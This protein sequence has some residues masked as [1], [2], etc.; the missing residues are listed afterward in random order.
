MARFDWEQRK[1]NWE[2]AVQQ[3]IN[4]K[5]KAEIVEANYFDQPLLGAAHRFSE[6]IEWK[7]VRELIGKPC[8]IAVDIGA[9]N[10]IVSY[11]LAKDGWKTIAI[12]PDPSPLVGADAIRNL[13]MQAGIEI[14][15]HQAMGEN[16]KLGSNTASIVIARQVLHHANNLNEFAKEIARILKPGGIMVSLRDHV[17]SGPHQLNSFLER[18]PLHRYY[19]GENAFEISVYRHAFISAGLTIVKELKSFDSVVNYAPKNQND[20]RREIAG[21]LGPI[22]FL[23]DHAL[24]PTMIMTAALKLLTLL[25]RRPG[26]LVSFVCQKQ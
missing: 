2:D 8:G 21:R 22:G 20:M 19:G 6:G 7:A 23:A 9:G 17:I 14:E 13:A 15:V 25:D 16:L 12:E 3:L 5:S 24:K 18:H 11:A 10:G 4:D 1:V 26:R